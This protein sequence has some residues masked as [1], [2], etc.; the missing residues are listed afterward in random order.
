MTATN[1]SIKGKVFAH[2]STCPDCG[3]QVTAEQGVITGPLGDDFV[4]VQYF[5]Q[6]SGTITWGRYVIP[7]ADLVDFILYDSI[8]EMDE[9]YKYGG[10]TS[11]DDRHFKACVKP[12]WDAE[13]AS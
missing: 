8:E 12:K 4:I 7:R 5:D 13:A 9:H 2:R 6:I 10:I 11:R 1:Y 3:Q